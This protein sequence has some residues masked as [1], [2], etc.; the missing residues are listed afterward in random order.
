MAKCP[1]GVAIRSSRFAGTVSSFQSPPP[2]TVSPV[3]AASSRFFHLTDK[4]EVVAHSSLHIDVFGTIV[5]RRKKTVHHFIVEVARVCESCAVE[6]RVE[7]CFVLRRHIVF[8]ALGECGE[9]LTSLAGQ[10]SRGVE[11]TDEDELP[12]LVEDAEHL[13]QI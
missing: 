11:V 1:F 12:E 9:Y 7:A 5:F 6:Q 4:R 8:V 10:A 2:S 3:R 13:A